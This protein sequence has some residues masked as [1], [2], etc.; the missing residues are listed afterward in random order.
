MLPCRAPLLSQL[1]VVSEGCLD[2]VPD[3]VRVCARQRNDDD[4]GF[5]PGYGEHLAGRLFDTVRPASRAQIRGGL[6]A[7]SFG[8]DARYGLDDRFAAVGRQP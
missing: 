8:D 2:A 3:S 4:A 1:S 7:H 5:A 6:A